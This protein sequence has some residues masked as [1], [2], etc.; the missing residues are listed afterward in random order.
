MSQLEHFKTMPLESHYSTME[1][2]P[3]LTIAQKE[4]PKQYFQNWRTITQASFSTQAV[5]HIENHDCN[6]DN[7]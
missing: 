4:Q 2:K 5:G 7:Y 6:L 3:R 1:A